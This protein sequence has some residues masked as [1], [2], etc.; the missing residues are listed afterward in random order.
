MDILKIILIC[1]GAVLALIVLLLLIALIRTLIMPSHKATYKPDPDPEREKK[2]AETL[3][4]M[5]RCETVSY[6][7]VSDPDKF[8]G[9]HKVLAKLF[10]LVF[11][12]LEVNDIEGNLLIYWKGRSSEKPLVLMSHQDVVPAEGKWIHEPFS[13][14]IA[15][16]RVWGRGAADTKGSLMCFLSATE[17]LLEEGYVPDQ[18]LYLSSSCTEEW[19]GPGCPMIV[20]E[21]KKRGVRPYLVCDEGGNIITDPVDGVSGNFA[22]MGVVEKGM[23]NVKFTAK[24]AGGHASFPAK[25]NPIARL[26]AFVCE[27]EKGRAFKKKLMPEVFTMFETFAPYATFGMKY[28]FGNLWLFKPLLP[29]V[30]AQLSP[31]LGAMVRTTVAFT[32]QSGSENYNSIPQEATLG[33]NVRF[34]PH[35]GMDE[36]L[37]I[38]ETVAAKYKITMEVIDGENFSRIADIKGSAFRLVKDTAEKT[39][40]GIVT[41]PFILMGSTDATIYDEICDT[42]I[43]FAPVILGDEQLECIHAANENI[44]TNCLPGCVDFYKNLIIANK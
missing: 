36:S 14:D 32:M 21:L 2:Y 10:P 19:G 26:S 24:G 7:G 39:F 33:A 17:E 8:R 13:G 20:K 22:M 38:L 34:I 18:D 44:E 9:F 3:G 25:N 4:E 27:I 41:S 29:T 11:E 12:K 16:G 43:R 30:M 42:V 31:S 6:T 15:Y 5:I 35:Q 37:K 23:A 28:V 40:P 1:L